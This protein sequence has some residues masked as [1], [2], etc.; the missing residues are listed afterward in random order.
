MGIN[1]QDSG[2]IDM[3]EAWRDDNENH[4][5]DGNENIFYDGNDD[6]IHSPADGKF[7][8]PQCEGMYCDNQAKTSIL[9][10]A[11]VLIMA[12][13]RNPT[14]TL[15]DG[16]TGDVYVNNL[17]E[18]NPVP[19]INIGAS[20]DFTFSF[21][22]S[23]LQ[24]LPIDSSVNITIEGAELKGL[25]NYTQPNTNT[26]GLKTLNFIV[27]NPVDN[28][29]TEAFLNITIDSVRLGN[30]ITINKKINLLVP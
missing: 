8:G 16:T 2:F 24:A 18:D 27:S 6:G 15:A 30:I 4:S 14:Y 23:Q 13:A 29:E 3:Q 19:E 26:A 1:P 9:R 21:A 12:D 10:K 28:E 11:L 5:K 7:N 22:D 17:G 20:Q 25:V